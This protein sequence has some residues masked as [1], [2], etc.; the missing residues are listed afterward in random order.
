[1]L[2]SDAL[3]AAGG[4]RPDTYLGRVLVTRLQRDSSRVQLRAVLRDTCGDVINDLALR[5]DD[6]IQVFSATRSAP[7]ARCR[8]A[9][10]C[11]AAGASRTAPG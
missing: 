11:A 7:T 2:L 5:D 6:E 1:M 9:A 8:S 4:P 10:R 3:R